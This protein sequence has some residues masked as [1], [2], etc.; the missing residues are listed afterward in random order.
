MPRLSIRKVFLYVLAVA[1]CLL[2]ALNIQQRTVGLFTSSLGGGRSRVFGKHKD[3]RANLPSGTGGFGILTGNE[4]EGSKSEGNQ[5]ELNTF[6]PSDIFLDPSD[7]TI[8]PP[9]KRPWYMR[10]G[11]V[12]PTFKEDEQD[13]DKS[14]SAN[15]VFPDDYPNHDRIPEQLMF[16]PPRKYVPENQEDSNAPLK[17]ILLWNGIQSW[18]GLRAGRGTFLKGQ[19]SIFQF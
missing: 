2:L 16:L 5:R 12:R 10:D 9:E 3:G 7:M 8:P 4:I 19:Y 1:S 17:K 11:K 15:K 6:V 14:S 18:G 13:S